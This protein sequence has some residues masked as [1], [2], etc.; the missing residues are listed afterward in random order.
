MKLMME[1]GSAL[2]VMA[3]I[4][5]LARFVLGGL[6]IIGGLLSSTLLTLLV[7]PAV[8]QLATRSSAAQ[9]PASATADGEVTG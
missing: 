7:I 3:V 9:Q 8:Y 5:F 6:P 1:P 4:A 2:L